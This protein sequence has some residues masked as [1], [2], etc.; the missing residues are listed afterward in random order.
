MTLRKHTLKLC[1]KFVKETLNHQHLQSHPFFPQE[2]QSKI[3][4][5]TLPPCILAI[6]QWWGFYPPGLWFELQ[7]LPHDTGSPGVVLL[8]RI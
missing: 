8:A 7:T 6:P 3:I 4:N 2:H 1:R 5:R